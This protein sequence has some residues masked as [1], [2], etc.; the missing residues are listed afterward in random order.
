MNKI[1][2]MTGQ[3]DKTEPSDLL[4]LVENNLL[5]NL[6]KITGID[7]ELLKK[8]ERIHVEK[9]KLKAMK[10][11]NEK[12]LKANEE[13]KKKVMLKNCVKYKKRKDNFRSYIQKKL[14]FD[15]EEDDLNAEEEMERRYFN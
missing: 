3:T 2:D 14:E 4:T 13:K 9:R 15:N 7:K 8:C 10:E 6:N 11:F 1:R 12:M 5:N